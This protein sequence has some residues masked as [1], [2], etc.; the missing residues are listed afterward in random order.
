MI[1]R[2]IS[3]R[4][5]LCAAVFC[6]SGCNSN[7]L[8]ALK[9][10]TPPPFGY[11]DAPTAGTTITGPTIEVQGWVLDASD[12]QPSITLSVDA[13]RVE[14]VPQRITQYFVGPGE[15]EVGLLRAATRPP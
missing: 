4:Q 5:L 7:P 8:S 13:E 15:R 6:L 14:A 11:L 3:G 1:G 2:N 12:T 10:A 9:P